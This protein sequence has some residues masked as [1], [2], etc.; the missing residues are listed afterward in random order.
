MD[1]LIKEGKEYLFVSNID[2]LG[3]IVDPKILAYMIQSKLD[4]LMEV[5]DKTRADIKGGTLINYKGHLRLLEVSQ[6][7]NEHLQDFN[8]V[9]LFK[10]FNTNNIWI[11][12]RA[13][14]EMA[15]TS[16]LSLDII[17]NPKVIEGEGRKVIQLE[18]AIGA[19]IK[20]FT[21]AQA[22][23]VPR[24]RFLPVKNCSD[25]FLVQSDLYSMN[26]GFLK[27]N[28]LR[29]FPTI[30]LIKL[31]DGF[32]KVASFKK[33]FPSAPKIVELEHLTVV[34]DVHFGSNVTLKGTVIIVAV[35][36]CRIDI[37]SG[38]VLE[39]KVIS[40]NLTITDH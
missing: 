38:S 16:N 37:P 32:R 11:R 26:D 15:N 22:I 30:P 12:T 28:P 21:N 40:G 19:A 29:P 18:T 31:G 1:K 34:G 2:N 5:T 25:L 4:F 23:N 9:K 6:V 7:P 36:G 14:K 8:S 33:R 3:A 13:L 27:I 24:S 20:H 35:D 10:I 17:V 39:D